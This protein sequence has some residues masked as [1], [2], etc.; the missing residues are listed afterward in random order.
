MELPAYLGHVRGIFGRYSYTCVTI[1]ISTHIFKEIIFVMK[2]EVEK[3][4]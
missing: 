3:S 4:E 1:Y 2:T